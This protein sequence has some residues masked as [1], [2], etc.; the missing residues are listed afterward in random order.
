ME[1]LTS[2]IMPHSLEAEQ[3]VLGAMLID[4]RCVADVVNIV[5]P[6]AFY[7]QQNRDIFETIYTMFNFS[8]PIDPV[9]VLNKMK[10]R[11]VADEKT[12][13]YFAQLVEVTPTA[14]YATRYAQIV[15]DKALLRNLAEASDDIQNTVFEGVGTPDEILESA[16]KKIYSIRKG[17]TGDTLQKIG[18]ILV[19]VYARLGE[20]AASKSTITGLSTGLRDLDKKINGL[21]NSNLIFIAARPGMGKTSLALNMALNV[22]KKSGKTVAIFSL[23]MSREELAMRL[24]S[25]ESYVDSQKL[26]T[27]RLSEDDWE[28]SVL[29]PARFPQRISVW[30]TTPRSPLHRSMRNAAGWKTSV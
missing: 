10:E 30:T 27:G 17:A 13:D 28:R 4:N 24:I 18:T 29:R 6:D 25:G 16:E 5:S 23:E 3:S 8:E 1:E 26:A 15:H 2:R 7:V 12:A 21:N 22:A 19:D 20:L 9:M 14:A 11:G